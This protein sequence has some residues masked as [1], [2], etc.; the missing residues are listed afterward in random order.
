MVVLTHGLAALLARD[1]RDWHTLLE[2]CG[3]IRTHQHAHASHPL[4]LLRAPR[5]AKPPRSVMK[6]RRHIAFPRPPSHASKLS[7]F[8][9]HLPK[10]A[11]AVKREAEEDWSLL[12]MREFAN[13]KALQ[14]YVESNDLAYLWED[15]RTFASRYEQL[16][17]RQC[18]VV[19]VHTKRGLA[20][21][22]LFAK[23][24]LRAEFEGHEALA[25]KRTR[26]QAKR[27]AKKAN[28]ASRREHRAL[29]IKRKRL[30][31]KRAAKEA[32]DARGR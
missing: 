5:A 3:L 31:T 8:V 22:L 1:G 27:A 13:Q 12:T 26:L 9:Q 29:A 2:F 19:A 17:P 7:G 20:K 18:E 23:A 11:P 4:G 10:T 15:G 16:S 30:R 6:S 24:I 21:A 25:I 32:T 28:D 14:E